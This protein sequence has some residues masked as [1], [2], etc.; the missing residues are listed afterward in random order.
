MN[1]VTKIDFEVRGFGAEFGDLPFKV[2]D[3][4]HEAIAYLVANGYEAI[5]GT[6]TGPTQFAKLSGSARTSDGHRLFELFVA[7]VSSDHVVWVVQHED[8]SPVT[9][10]DGMVCVFSSGEDART[11]AS[12]IER[13]GMGVEGDEERFVGMH[14]A[15]WL[16]SR[17]VAYNNE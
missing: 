10:V 12:A 14:T 13:I 5:N 1:A 7:T 11:A 6:V 15:L 3:E 16:A 4:R 17:V 2:F 8:G 9:G